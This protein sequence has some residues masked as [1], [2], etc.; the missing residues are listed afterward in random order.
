MA[1]NSSLR[2]WRRV[3]QQLLRDTRSTGLGG[4]YEMICGPAT[5]TRTVSDGFLL[6]V[7][8]QVGPGEFDSRIQQAETRGCAYALCH[9]R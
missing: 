7:S 5:L 4:V 3:R 9:S 2:N 8:S 6:V 1:Q